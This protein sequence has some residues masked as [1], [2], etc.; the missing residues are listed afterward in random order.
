MTP[1]YG[2]TVTIISR[3]VTGQDADG[4]DVYG[5]TTT[6][7]PHSIFAPEG[8]VERVQGQ[9][10][11]T[12]SPKVYLPDGAPV[13]KATDKVQVRGLLY[14][15]DGEPQVFINPFTGD[16]PGPVLNLTRVTG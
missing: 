10:I 7:V 14:D 8:S 16:Q 2:E 4:N 13:P 5:T 3:T 9:D 11:V 12:T 1:E 15:I 6:D